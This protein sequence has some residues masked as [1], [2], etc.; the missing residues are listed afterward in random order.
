MALKG[1]R[2]VQ[3]CTSRYACTFC[4]SYASLITSTKPADAKNHV[5]LKQICMET[6]KH[7]LTTPKHSKP[8]F[9]WQALGCRTVPSMWVLLSFL[10]VPA[11]GISFTS[12][13]EL[14]AAVVA[15]ETNTER[16]TWD[17]QN[18]LVGSVV[19]LQ[20]WVIWLAVKWCVFWLASVFEVD[21]CCQTHLE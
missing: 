11:Y 19:F 12:K 13:A 8:I 17:M 7:K 18:N 9:N 20:T 1:Y 4:D 3:Q 6:V 21:T 15:W 5:T 10:A 16:L 14:G 2:P